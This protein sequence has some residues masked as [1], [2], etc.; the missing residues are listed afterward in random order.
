MDLK[1]LSEEAGKKIEEQ[2]QK[3]KS[4]LKKMMQGHNFDIA[5]ERLI[6]W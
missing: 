5:R 3:L 4:I 1:Q 2:K 6:R